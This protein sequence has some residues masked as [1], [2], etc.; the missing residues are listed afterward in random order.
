MTA[1]VS[2]AIP[3]GEAR[4]AK[5]YEDGSY[6]CPWCGGA[7]PSP[8]HPNYA[9]GE[10][11]V[12]IREAWEAHG[13]ANPACFARVNPPMP[14]EV[15]ERVRAEAQARR[16]EEARRKR[17]HEAAMARIDAERQARVDKWAQ[18]SAEAEKRGACI[19]CLRASDWESYGNPWNAKPEGRAKFVRHRGACPRA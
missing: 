14:I 3:T 7:V 10:Y 1:A 13:C 12:Y 15:I 8:E 11:P 19:S 2:V 6:S 5:T 9:D 16:D 18:V 17:D 4:D